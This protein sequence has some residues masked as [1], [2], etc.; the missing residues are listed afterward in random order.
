M[1]KASRRREYERLRLMD[2]E[3]RKENEKEEFEKKHDELKEKDEA[4]TNKNKARREKA[5]ARKQK[6]KSGANMDVDVVEGE[7]PANNEDGANGTKTNG[8]DA[9]V[10][11]K[12][13]T[14]STGDG[15][16]KEVEE[17]G[18]I[19]HDDD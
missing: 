12:T 3:M 10:E 15:V 9:V 2:E 5:K 14:T 7:A 6:A 13:S 4:K 17:S 1:Y 16:Q 19:I 11:S 18:I 8:K